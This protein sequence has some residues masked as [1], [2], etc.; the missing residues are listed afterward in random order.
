MDKTSI[1]TSTQPALVLTSTNNTEKN[2]VGI[3]SVINDVN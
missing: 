2:D 1:D 3:T